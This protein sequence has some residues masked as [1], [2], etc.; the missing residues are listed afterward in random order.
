MVCLGLEP[1]AAGWKAQ[2]NPLSY[3]KSSL[4]RTFKK[5]IF[6]FLFQNRSPDI[7]TTSSWGG[8]LGP[9]HRG[10]HDQLFFFKKNWAKLGLFFILSF[11]QY[12]DKYPK[13]DFIKD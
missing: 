10:E 5:H 7:G 4:Y 9:E 6:I 8:A 3:G 13:F 12:N 2:T 1:G 11:S